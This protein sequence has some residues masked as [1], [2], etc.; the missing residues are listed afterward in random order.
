MAHK[1]YTKSLLCVVY[2]CPNIWKNPCLLFPWNY[3]PYFSYLETSSS[4]AILIFHLILFI[5]SYFVQYDLHSKHHSSS[6]HY[7]T[8]SYVFLPTNQANDEKYK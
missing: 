5:T 1:Y 7:N 2:E 8:T 3:Y 4:I 6:Q